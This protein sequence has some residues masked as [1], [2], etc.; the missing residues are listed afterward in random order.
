MLSVESGTY[1]FDDI[2]AYNNLFISESKTILRLI[3]E[4]KLN[5]LGYFA[6]LLISKSFVIYCAL[7][8][9]CLFII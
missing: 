3:I 6:T 7:R 9:G 5:A 4:I 1:I 2:V 8:H